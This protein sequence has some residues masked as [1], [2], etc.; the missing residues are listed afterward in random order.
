MPIDI[1]IADDHDVI[2]EGIKNILQGH[3]EYKV[4]A[5][6]SNGHE[7]LEKVK[8]MEPDVLL[9]DISMPKMSGL[10]AIKEVKR[11]CPQ[12]NILIITVYKAYAYIMKAFEVGAKGY[13]SKEKAAEELLPALAKITKGKIYLTP[14]LSSY[15]VEKA[16]DNQASQLNNKEFLTKRE[17]EILHLVGEG[18]TAKEIAKL[19]YISRRTVENYKNNLLKKLG[20][21]RTS[22]L[23]KYAIKHNIVDI[24]EY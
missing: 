20:L 3:N 7:V 10:D 2:R 23:I 18:K 6:A 13:L 15:L 11:I 22:D 12:T 19:L 1:I 4:V 9:L 21:H 8:E 24:E 17:K 16:V 14:S 5:E